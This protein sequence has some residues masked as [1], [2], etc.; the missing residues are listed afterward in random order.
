LA[1]S[2]RQIQAGNCHLLVGKSQIQT[3]IPDFQTCTR[4]LLVC[5]S[6][7]LISKWRMPA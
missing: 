5:I 3:C 7:L 2:K 4:R 6:R 1:A